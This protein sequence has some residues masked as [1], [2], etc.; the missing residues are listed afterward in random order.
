VTVAFEV[1]HVGYDGLV[2]IAGGGQDSAREY[3]SSWEYRLGGE[4]A[5]LARR[6]VLALRGG[7]WVESPGNDL[8]HEDI[9]HFAL[10]M[11]FAGEHLQLDL[12]ADLSEVVDTA[13]LS[14]IYSF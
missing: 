14:V 2:R 7:A 9:T 4:Y 3:R 13:A 11:G 5:F 12:A 10:G 6:P 8:A 1:D